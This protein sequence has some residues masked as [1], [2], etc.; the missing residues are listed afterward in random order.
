MVTRSGPARLSPVTAPLNLK[1]HEAS[2]FA[3]YPGYGRDGHQCDKDGIEPVESDVRQDWFLPRP[4]LQ[5]L[6]DS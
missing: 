4:R 3:S 5:L 2:L 1:K 6:P